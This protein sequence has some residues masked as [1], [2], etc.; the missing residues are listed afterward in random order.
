MDMRLVID[1]CKTINEAI[2]SLYGYDNSNSRKKFFEYVVLNDI[3]ISHLRKRK[4]RYERKIKECPIC[5]IEFE[6]I[7]NHKHE[8]ITCSHKCANTYF[9]SGKDNP[10]WKDSTYRSTCFQY[11]K[12]ECIICGENKIVAVHHY[13]ENPKNNSIDNL[14]PLCPTHHQYVHS[15]YKNEVISKIDEYRKNFI[16]QYNADIV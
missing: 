16:I 5:G 10:N 3:D 6:T 14:I 7:I 11:H 15:K 8:K 13:D 9:R 12:K 2:Y 1:K 4:L